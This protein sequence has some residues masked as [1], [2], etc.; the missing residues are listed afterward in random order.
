MAKFLSGRQSQLNIGI[1]S[2]T[3]DKT[4]LQITGK[5]GIGTTEAGGRNLY[6]VGNTETTGVTTLSS[7]GGITTTGG[8]FYVGGDL[9]VRD[10]II[11]DEFTGRNINI[12]GVG[13]IA[14]VSGTNL[15][16]TNATISVA[17]INTINAS[18]IISTFGTLT[19]ISGSELNYSGVGTFG[20]LNVGIGGTVIT[21]TP[22]GLV[23]I[24]TTNP[25]TPLQIERYGIKTGI[26][27]FVATSGVASD[28]DSFIVSSTDFKVVEYTVHFQNQS[29]FQVQKV[30]L[31][32]DGSISYS[33]EYGIMYEPNLLVSVGSTISSNTCKLQVT[34]ES[35][36]S[37]II[38]YRFSRG[39]VL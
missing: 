38:T 9:Y 32:Q 22:N 7:S 15:S 31:M 8:D 27:T 10:D 5:V 19:N 18:N 21:T 13:T 24:L 1:S 35:G 3:V 17:N 12:T 6:V 14:T 16:Y 33:E 30:L 34:P 25:Q 36:I 37:G 26:G 4:V 11:F 2:S 29:G 28:I 23:G 39:S 20:R